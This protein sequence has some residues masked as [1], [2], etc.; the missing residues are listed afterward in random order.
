MS[1]KSAWTA[2]DVPDLSGKTIIVTGGNSGIG[3]EAALQLARKHAQVV[4]ACRNIDK[5]RAA[6]AQI[7]A[8]S[9]G[10]S[11]EVME[12]NLSSLASVRSFAD[13]FQKQ[14]QQ[15]HVLCNNAGVMA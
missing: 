1:N 9:P 3:Y 11:L 7:A 14:H 4:L 5:A 13:T 15:L 2:D 10:A 8:A 12:L 6:A